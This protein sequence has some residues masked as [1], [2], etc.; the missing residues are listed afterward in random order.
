MPADPRVLP[1]EPAGPVAH[2]ALPPAV[3]AGLAFT[4]SGAVL[5]LEILGIRL[6]APYVGLTLEVTTSIIGVVLAGIAIGSA[7]GGRIA[8][9]VDPRRLVALLLGTG[10]VLALMTVPVVRALG[11]PASGDDGALG[12]TI[13]A[14]L[15][16]ATVLSAVT[17]AVARLQL[18]DLGETG[19][20]YGTLSAW[21]TA[22][23]L[24]GTFGTGFVLVPLM[25]VSVAVLAVGVILVLAGVLT[26]LRWRTT[27]PA[28]GAGLLAGALL[29][30]LASVAAGTPC[31]AESTYHCARVEIDPDR[32]GGRLLL[33]DDLRHSYVDLGDPEHLEFDYTRWIGD[34]IDA[35]RPRSRAV[36]A[37][38]VGGGGFTLPRYVLATRPGSR[39][40]VLEVDGELVDLAR[41]R[42]GL[43]TSDALR[44]DVGDARVTLG[45]LPDASADIVVGDAFGQL[46]VPW[47]LTTAEWHDDVR[48]VLRPGGVYALNVIDRGDLGL[49]R[50]IAATLLDRFADVRLVRERGPARTGNVVFLAS[51]RTL[52]ADVRST[53]RGAQTLDR[54]AVADLAGDADVLR[55][56]DAPVD[57]LHSTR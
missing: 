3:A 8:D 12:L 32:A 10:G 29:L 53:A 23:A 39:T 24:A 47:H 26:A 14:L 54:D 4:S 13:V 5:V 30:G 11:P 2:P 46:A 56:D 22:G 36:D 51:A 45:G 18:R 49:V 40:R 19:T 33:L 48:R 42:L 16:A 31:D 17:P 57:Q 7:A 44:V 34:A 55:D 27:T 37:V 6:L 21:A 35:A 38:F 43:R 52:P 25:P 20:V 1:P 41:D 9:R 50:A 28:Q 15:P